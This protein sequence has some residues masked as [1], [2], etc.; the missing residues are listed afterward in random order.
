MANEIKGD[1]VIR[2]ADKAGRDLKNLG[3][4]AAKAGSQVEDL[5][6][7]A[8][9]AAQGVDNLGEQAKDSTSSVTDLGDGVGFL[10]SEVQRLQAHLKELTQQL[11]ATGDTS[12]LKDIR[13]DKRQLSMFSKL[14]A[15]I[16]PEA[17]S[18]GIEVG[19]SF[20]DGIL[21]AVSAAT[22]SGGPYLMGA[23]AAAA[24]AAT[25]FIGSAVGAA[26][27]GGVGAGGIVGGV[28]LAA[29]DPR[30]KAAAEDVG[31]AMLS[32]LEP[33]GKSFIEPVIGSLDIFKRAVA[34][35]SAKAA[36]G[37]AELAKE[38]EPLAL[39]FAN[40]GKNAMPGFLKALDAARPILR[41][42]AAEL[43]EVGDALSDMFESFSE[44]GDG[45]VMALS[46]LMDIIKGSLILFGDFVSI[47][48]QTYE[49][50]IAIGTAVGDA[51]D[52][53]AR[54]DAGLGVALGI[55]P[56]LNDLVRGQEEA[57]NRSA[58]AASSGGKATREYGASAKAAAEEVK[59]LTDAVS[60]YLGIEMSVDEAQVRWAQGLIDLKKELLDG[61][62]VIDLNS[63]A[64]IKNRETMLGQIAIANQVREAAIRQGDGTKEAMDKANAGYV[65]SVKGLYDMAVQAGFSKKALDELFAPYLDGP[66]IATVEVRA[67]G[68]LEA[69]ARARELNRLL[70]SNVAGANA[71][72]GTNPIS[73]RASGGPIEA[74]RPYVVGEEGPELI[75][76][77]QSGT[78]MTAAQ[79]KAMQS[80]ASGGSAVGGGSRSVGVQLGWSAS[81][82]AVMRTLAEALTPYIQAVVIDGGGSTQVMLGDPGLA[83]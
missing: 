57:L 64:G 66:R 65:A 9:A 26:V 13:K 37:M 7:D 35:I 22:K 67:P 46:A 17:A 36:P 5:G 63:E 39:A 8:K 38:V 81:M 11:N 80:G 28:M 32:S 51:A 31:K 14:A 29:K 10:D 73:G 47:A 24:V 19:K 45:A 59:L 20:G 56:W 43:P 41:V 34:D 3:D 55:L 58:S 42:L 61:K 68:L 82:P 76:P 75:I 48:G 79:T 16:A 21:S 27:L 40:M 2:G 62:R 30:V 70:G 33:I 12:L 72:A 69:L 15:E 78:V 54:W 49:A 1:I 53:V 71:R 18:A 4:S 23:L 44:G 25:P 77:S 83:V 74:G 50:M 52:E 60:E 6:V